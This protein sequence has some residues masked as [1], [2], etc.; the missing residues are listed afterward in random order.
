MKIRRW[1]IFRE[2]FFPKWKNEI[3]VLK[4]KLKSDIELKEKFIIK[5]LKTFAIIRN[6]SIIGLPNEY[7]ND[8]FVSM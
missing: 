3:V 5:K 4:F 6:A 2:F 1:F 8:Y 7:K